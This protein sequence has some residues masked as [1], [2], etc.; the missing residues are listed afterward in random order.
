[1]GTKELIKLTTNK[2]TIAILSSAVALF[3]TILFLL[4]VFRDRSPTAE[5][6]F[7]N[8]DDFVERKADGTYDLKPERKRKL[9]EDILRMRQGAEQYVLVAAED[10]NYECLT[11]PRGV[12]FLYKG[13]IAKIGTTVQGEGRY[14]A[15]WLKRMK[16]KYVSEFRGNVQQVLEKEKIRLGLYPLEVENLRR[17]NEPRGGIDRYKLARPPLNTLDR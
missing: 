17:P 11:C 12:F 14:D 1:M 3:F 4:W 15:N 10:G 2:K 9:N 8:F 7:E 16:L 6:K 13:E 5:R